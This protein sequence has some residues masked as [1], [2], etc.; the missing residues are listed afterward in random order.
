MKSRS[1]VLL[2]SN[3]TVHGQGYLDHVEEEIKNFLG[4]AK[5]VLFFPFALHDRDGYAGKANERY[6][7]MGYSLESVHKIDNDKAAIEKADAFFIGG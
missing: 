4:R 1:R 3:S 7:A 5:T 2:I 6:E